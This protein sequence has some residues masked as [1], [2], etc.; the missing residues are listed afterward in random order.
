MYFI[1]IIQEQQ[2][3]H[4]NKIQLNQIW[5]MAQVVTILE[6]S[7]IRMWHT[8]NNIQRTMEIKGNKYHNNLLHQ[9][10]SNLKIRLVQSR[11]IPNS[12]NSSHHH[13]LPLSIVPESRMAITSSNRARPISSVALMVILVKKL[14]IF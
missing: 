3:R 1:N 11:A 8:D 7:N 9:A 10:I 2:C 13:L 12:P 6:G 5:S 14:K 4:N